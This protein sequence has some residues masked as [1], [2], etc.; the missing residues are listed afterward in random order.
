MVPMNPLGGGLIPQNA[1]RFDFLRSEDD[2][3]VVAAAIRFNVSNPNIT[4]ALV[5][6]TTKQH[7]EEAVAAVDNFI[8]HDAA[9]IA[10]MREKILDTFDDLCTGCAYC[11]PC[12]EGVLIPKLMDA[13]NFKIL[14]ANDSQA[15][16]NRLEWH[17]GLKPE[18]A[19]ACSLCGNC[20]DKCTQRI[21]IRDRLTEIT[22]LAEEE[23]KDE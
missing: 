23:Q 16:R 7:V 20:E 4:S 21:S 22:Q 18:D 19:K 14:S 5:G 3:S 11:L 15:I 10:S 13:Y 9:H 12:P 17:W 2:P 8:P 6:F 1:E